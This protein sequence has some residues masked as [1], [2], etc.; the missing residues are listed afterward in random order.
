M[1]VAL[2][3]IILAAQML[4]YLTLRAAISSGRPTG[5]ALP[6]PTR[7]A[8]LLQLGAIT[9]D[10]AGITLVAMGF[11]A[12]AAEQMLNAWQPTDDTLKVAR[13]D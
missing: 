2:Q 1:I 11:T 7:V 12:A 9:R 4:I 6:T 13:D 8:E 3:L 10:E 5:T